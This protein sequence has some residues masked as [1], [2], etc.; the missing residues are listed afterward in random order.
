MPRNRTSNAPELL[1]PLDREGAEPL[2]RQLEQG[3]REAIRSGRLVADAAL[4]SS[5]LLSEQLRVSRGVVVEAYEQLTAEG[6]LAAR[7]GGATT[8]ACIPARPATRPTVASEN[9]YRFDFRPG[10]PD[11]AE[12]PREEWLRS[13]RRALD[14][15]PSERFGY[16]DG[17]G[18]PELRHALAAYLDRVRGTCSDPEDVVI[19]A[20]FSQGLGL[21]GRVLR[22][23]GVRR[24]AMEDPSN[25]T[26]RLIMA[27]L[28]IEAIAVP[29]DDD[30]MQV[31]AL[32][33]TALE[34]VG[35]VVVTPA[36]QYPVGSVLTPDRRSALVAWARRTGGY[37]VEDDYD[38]EYRYDREPIGAI[39]GLAPERVIYA[40]TASK[41]LAPG[42]RLGWLIA[43]GDLVGSLAGARLA[44]D[45]GA[46]VL[47]QLA[48][49]D[50]LDQGELDRH[51]RRV[52]PVYRA[53]RDALLDALS[54]HL[55]T[56]DP[57][58]ASAGLH[59]L[60]WLPDGTDERAVVG[61]SVGAGVGLNGLTRR[62]FAPGG[63]SGLI[64]GYGVIPERDV[65][66]GI[67]LLAGAIAGLV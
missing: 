51:L 52:R 10:R 66:P 42:L 44:L 15:V 30:G 37:I 34:G 53:R 24:V 7:P 25:P 38:A 2:H 5:R 3:I 31:D 19:S 9:R 32:G 13:M 12:F 16:L 59:V 36:H 11:L 14:G 45:S 61:A 29:V 56:L 64:F 48:F 6:Y 35:A 55:P 20:G 23:L 40:G 17:R 21:I 58:G 22:D 39:Q 41:T 4:P 27:D 43:P 62:W 33:S 63:R 1:L 47:D 60:A 50:F 28:G 18:V 49:A 8:V 54:R 57:C 26:Y 67:R 65:E 46:P